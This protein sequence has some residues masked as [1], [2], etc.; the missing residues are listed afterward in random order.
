MRGRLATAAAAALL[1]L[2]PARGIPPQ[3]RRSGATF[4]SR[5]TQS[6]QQDDFANP[7]MLWVQEGEAL[8]RQKPGP[9]APSCADCHG[10]PAS[11]KGAAARY[12]ALDEA[13]GEPID[14]PGRVDQCR[15]GRQAMSPLPR[16]GQ[17]MLALTSLV[18]LQSRG[19][20][21]APPADA[22][23]EPFRERGRR[24]F[25]ERL[26]QLALSCA[27][28][29]DERWG[30]HL[31]GSTIPQGHPTAYPIYR[32]EWQ[33]VGSLER[34]LRNCLTGVRAE[35]F[36]YGA[37]EYIE[38]ELYLMSRAAGMPLESPGVRP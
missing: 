14:L 8:W 18:A 24:L 15:T 26:G 16:E 21:I 11:M 10:E 34:R 23:L 36:P 19:L 17:E 30:R 1:A 35:P 33:G 6:L 29:H 5:E 32:L 20:P 38:L 13:T 25:G 7:A 12:P 31:G 28:C 9:A 22:R 4:M 37:R 3:E 2:W 27:Q